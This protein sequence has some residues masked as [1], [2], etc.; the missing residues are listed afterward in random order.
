MTL[1]PGVAGNFRHPS[2]VKFNFPSKIK[3]TEAALETRVN[4]ILGKTK[5]YVMSPQAGATKADV[6]SCTDA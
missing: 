6:S 5:P 4:Q 1:G 2:P 3:R